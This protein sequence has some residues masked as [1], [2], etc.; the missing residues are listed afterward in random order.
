MPQ[1]APACEGRGFLPI[2]RMAAP[3]GSLPRPDRDIIQID[4]PQSY[5]TVQFARTLD[6]LQE[7]GW[8][9]QSIFPH[10]GNLMTLAIAAGF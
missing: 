4:V 2:G 10:R 9:R 3:P 7:R 6:P 8:A 5:G 1:K